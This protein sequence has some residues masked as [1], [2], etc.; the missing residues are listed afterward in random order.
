MRIIS[1]IYGGRTLI[2]PK[3]DSVRPTSDKV[4]GAMFNMIGSRMTMDGAR[5]LDG[6]CGSGALGIEALSR[7]A[8]HCT[9]VD[10]AVRLC[11]ENIE[12]LGAS[13]QSRIVKSDVTR[14]GADA[15]FDLILI[16]PPYEQE[17]A[18]AAL[19]HLIASA[20][21]AE[22]ALVIVEESRYVAFSIP[23]GLVLDAQKQYGD[24]SV[25]VL[26]AA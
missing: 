16:D 13:A 15:P 26:R 12:K 25:Y 14:M 5:V 24:T 18:E 20:L 10:K 8:A 4:R 22:D 11:E 21:I 9:F 6:F 19:T 1:G 23:D 17:L 2:S 7:G 3:D